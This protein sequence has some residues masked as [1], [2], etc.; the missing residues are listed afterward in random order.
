[1]RIL[2]IIGHKNAGKTT[3]LV[4]LAREYHRLGRR[5]A[6]IKHASHPA[7]LDREGTDTWRH[8]HEGSTERTMIASPDIRVLFERAPDNT[9]P[10]TLALRYLGDV[11]LVLVEGFKRAPIPKVEVYRKGIGVPPLFDPALPNAQDWIAIVTDDPSLR[12]DCRVLRFMDTM[13]LSLLAGLSWERAKV[14]AP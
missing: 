14:L 7:L 1:M 13:W 4:A 8:F 9:D 10:E 11:D 3:L 5:V 12:A 6:S 2:S